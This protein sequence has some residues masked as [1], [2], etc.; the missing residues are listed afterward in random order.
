MPSLASDSGA[1]TTLQT[2]ANQTL[3]AAKPVSPGAVT[4]NQQAQLNKL[5]SAGLST[6]QQY[7]QGLGLKAASFN[8]EGYINQNILA[9][10][11]A[12]SV[13]DTKNALD[14][15]NLSSNTYNTYIKD[16]LEQE[17]QNMKLVLTAAA[18]VATIVSF[19]AAAPT[20]AAAGASAGEAAG[21][22][23][24]VGASTSMAPGIIGEI[25][26]GAGMVSDFSNTQL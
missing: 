6:M 26:L 1:S 10:Q 12:W 21:G 25:G 15:L 9:T 3:T 4:T 14:A 20:V 8:P 22:A 7:Y 18:I 2:I 11:A 16:Q 19:G 17:Q 24:A 23:A 5:K 13:E